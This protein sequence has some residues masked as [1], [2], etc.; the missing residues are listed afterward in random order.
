MGEIAYTEAINLMNY[1]AAV[2][3]VTQADERTDVFDDS[4]EPL[5]DMDKLN[6]QSCKQLIPFYLLDLK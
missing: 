2:I 4:Y 1:S 6:W 3:P 5:G